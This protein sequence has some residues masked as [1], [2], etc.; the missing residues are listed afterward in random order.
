[1]IRDEEYNKHMTGITFAFKELS[2]DKKTAIFQDEHHDV[3]IH[4]VALPEDKMLDHVKSGLKFATAKTKEGT[5]QEHHIL[6]P[7]HTVQVH[8]D[9]NDTPIPSLE[10]DR[11]NLRLSCD[12]KAMYTRFY[13]EERHSNRLMAAFVEDNKGAA[14]EM[15]IKMEGGEINMGDVF[16]EAMDLIG[17]S[18]KVS[19]EKARHDRISRMMREEGCNFEWSDYAL[20]E[21]EKAVER[22][23]QLRQYASMED[24]SDFDGARSGGGRNFSDDSDDEE[25]EDAGED[26]ESDGDVSMTE[27]EMEQMISQMDEN[28]AGGAAPT[29]P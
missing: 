19:Y 29:I 27:E 5:L 10:M 8:R 26:D 16:K 9:V 3:E 21:H 1:M 4:D 23:S 15:K 7:E 13:G 12:W 28:M 2:A 11:D 18:I 24:D 25:W 17:K 14:D 22:L 20:E 6:R